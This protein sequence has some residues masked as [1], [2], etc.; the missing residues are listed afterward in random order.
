MHSVPQ[1]LAAAGPSPRRSYFLIISK[2]F[3]P[4]HRYPHL[5][6]GSVE[7]RELSIGSAGSDAIFMALVFFIGNN[8]TA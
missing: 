2:V 7:N 1:F 3:Q 6:G 8:K 5:R 4:Q